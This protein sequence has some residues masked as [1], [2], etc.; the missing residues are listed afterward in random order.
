[1]ELKK[2]VKAELGLPLEAIEELVVSTFKERSL[3]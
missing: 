1:V 3:I 2:K